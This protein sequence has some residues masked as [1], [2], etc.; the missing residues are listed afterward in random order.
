MHICHTWLYIFIYTYCST[1]A[2]NSSP[3]M[4]VFSDYRFKCL[5]SGAHFAKNPAKSEAAHSKCEELPKLKCQLCQCLLLASIVLTWQNACYQLLLNPCTDNVC[6][7]QLI[8]AGCMAPIEWM[9]RRNVSMMMWMV[10]HLWDGAR[11]QE[12]L[13]PMHMWRWKTF[14]KRLTLINNCTTA[15]I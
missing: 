11:W 15:Y 4:C 14:A 6:E 12:G 10:E 9:R 2:K 7:A 3:K 13:L 5:L 8:Y 1:P